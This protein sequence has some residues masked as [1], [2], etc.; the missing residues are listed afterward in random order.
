MCTY[1]AHKGGSEAYVSLCLDATHAMPCVCCM[2]EVAGHP[3]PEGAPSPTGGGGGGGG[4]GG[5]GRAPGAG[6]GGGVPEAG[7]SGGLLHPQEEVVAGHPELEPVGVHLHPDG[8]CRGIYSRIETKILNTIIIV[9]L[10]LLL[11]TQFNFFIALVPAPG[12][13]MQII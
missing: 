10:Y 4:R 2:L 1:S 9:I 8:R 13:C 12:Y 6:E 5:G 11:E 7:G 3:E